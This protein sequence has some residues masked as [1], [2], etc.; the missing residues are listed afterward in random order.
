V[1][2]CGGSPPEV[3]RWCIIV[4]VELVK[5]QFRER[6]GHYLH[7]RAGRWP[8]DR[9]LWHHKACWAGELRWHFWA[10][11]AASLK[12]EPSLLGNVLDIGALHDYTA[13]NSRQSATKFV[14]HWESL[15]H[16]GLLFVSSHQ[17]LALSCCTFLSPHYLSFTNFLSHPVHV[18]HIYIYVNISVVLLAMLLMFVTVYVFYFWFYCTD[19]DIVNIDW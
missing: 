12:F 13:R 19:I 18:G 8:S 11:T 16:G 7:L 17:G 4:P 3:N 10:I 6:P 14:N 15:P 9:S 2:T 1:S 5:P